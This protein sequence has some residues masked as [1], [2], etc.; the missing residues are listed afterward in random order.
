MLTKPMWRGGA[1]ALTWRLCLLA[2]AGASPLFAPPLRAQ[3]LPLPG[4]GFTWE[5]VGDRPISPSDL[6]FGADGTLW[7]AAADGPHRLDLTGGFPGRWVLLYP[8]GL[9]NYAILP[10][11]PDTLLASTSATTRRSLDGGSSWAVAYDEGG[12]GLY[13]VP[14]SYS[15]G[16]RVLTGE[17]TDAAYSTD[18][19]GSYTQSV[20]PG[21]GTGVSAGADDFVAL[22]V[23]SSHPGRIL[24]AGR[25][26]VSISDDGGATFRESG[27]YG[28][29]F[30]YVGEALGVVE[31]S[32]GGY[33]AVMAGRISGQADSRVWVSE[34]GGETWRPDGGGV[35]IPEGPPFG[36]GGGA[37]AVL[38]LGGQSA[39][40]VL[41]RGTIYRTDDAG[42]TWEAV[43]RAPEISEDVGLHAA[44]LS[45]DGRLYVGLFDVGVARGWVYRTAEVVTA[46][47]PSV[48]EPAEDVLR[49]E[50]HPNPAD[51]T[52]TVTI[53][54]RTPA[55][56]R[57]V[58]YDALGRQAAV[59]VSGRFAAGRHEIALDG[60]GLL[61]GVY[62]L[63]VG[64]G[65]G[66][67]EAEKITLVK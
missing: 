31:R 1:L 44:V 23:G 39:F 65:D 43:G 53:T 41:G 61:P 20:I 30:G 22:P 25:W 9:F 47:E 15:F 67:V 2:G 60:S 37:H 52:A 26:G 55:E 56:V 57:A 27:L 14:L 45:L 59:L 42:Q 36:V 28:A 10:L 51:D 35:H 63:E 34:N 17:L 54:L 48:P 38:P 8:S 21:Q 6:T 40:V 50:V 49:V 19:G 13:A 16:G 4:E 58:L 18:R 29:T 66:Q 24:M 32:G 46:S 33:S 3:D 7:A 64:T 62:I 5:H 11:G 12:H